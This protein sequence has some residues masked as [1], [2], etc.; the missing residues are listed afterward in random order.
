MLTSVFGIPIK[1]EA[2]NKQ[3]SLPLYIAVVMNSVLHL[4][5][6]KDVL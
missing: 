5:M 3:N 4:L 6:S 1:Y 2:W